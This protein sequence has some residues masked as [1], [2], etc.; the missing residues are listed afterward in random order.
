MEKLL[1]PQ[2]NKNEKGGWA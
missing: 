1:D 2:A